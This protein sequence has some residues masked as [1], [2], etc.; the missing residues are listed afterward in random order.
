MPKPQEVIV[1]DKEVK[2]TPSNVEIH[3]DENNQP[4]KKEAPKDEP[5]YVRL[6][7]IDRISKAVENGRSW[8]TRKVSSLEEKMDRIISGLQQ[9]PKPIT[10]AVP[11][12]EWEE[13]LQKNWKG[14]VEELAD[15]RAEAKYKQF[16]EKE[17]EQDRI[18]AE[19]RK[20]NQLREDNKRKVVDRH[21][22]L[23]DETS[24]KSE[25]FR[26]VI[27]EHPEYLPNPFGPVLAMRDM[28]DKL[29]ELGVVDDNTRPLVDKEVARQVRTSGGAVP[30]GNPNAPSNKVVLTKDEKDFCDQQGLKYEIYAKNKK[31]TNQGVSS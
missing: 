1:D 22:E 24:Q 27:S 11:A 7:D 28:E 8:T 4:I 20:N 30:R 2:D 31:L 13:K 23:N 9:P 6:E 5:K 26:Q 12:D 10:P 3:L 15:A 29:R 18:V 19:D 17:I 16:R 21:K 25:L 14:T